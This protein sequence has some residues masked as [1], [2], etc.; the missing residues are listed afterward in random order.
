METI[1]FARKRTRQAG[2]AKAA[3]AMVE[4]AM[5]ASRTLRDAGKEHCAATAALTDEAPEGWDTEEDGDFVGSFS[6]V[7]DRF[8]E[9]GCGPLTAAKY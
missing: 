8:D 4:G 3:A 7:A 6:A 9:G 1:S 2:V 5:A